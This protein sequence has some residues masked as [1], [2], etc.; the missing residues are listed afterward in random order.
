MFS[1]FIEGY[2]AIGAAL[3]GDDAAKSSHTAGAAIAAIREK[4]ATHEGISSIG[5]PASIPPVGES[6]SI[7]P[8]GKSAA[9]LIIFLES[10]QTSKDLPTARV[11]FCL[12]SESLIAMLEIDGGN[13]IA[14]GGLFRV[15][16][17]MA[18]NNRGADW[19]Q[20]GREVRN[21]YFGASML[22]CGEIVTGYGSGGNGA[23]EVMDMAG[24]GERG[25]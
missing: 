7:P 23:P 10:L 16:C 14:A 2:L 6:A 9:E 8:F 13:D 19:V 21:P 24:M 5:E 25:R 4:N 22:N 3:S 1:G 12:L 11:A 15:H 17:P 18:F 20:R